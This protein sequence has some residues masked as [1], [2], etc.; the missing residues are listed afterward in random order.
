MKQS[1]VPRGLILVL[2]LLVNAGLGLCAG[3]LI[4]WLRANVLPDTSPGWLASAALIGIV[5]ADP[6][7]HLREGIRWNRFAGRFVIGV[8]LAYLFH[9]I[10]LMAV[11][12]KDGH[13]L[14][15]FLIPVLV[16]PL[17]IGPLSLTR[18]APETATDKTA[19]A[20]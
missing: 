20:D 9:T 8:G 14:M 6:C 18:A 11:E 2:D 19:L 10:T 17:F 7:R 1:A 5:I 3:F 15:L 12:G 16:A 13:V 4:A